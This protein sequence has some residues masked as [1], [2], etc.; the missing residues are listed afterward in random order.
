MLGL[1]VYWALATCT[2]LAGW[3][4]PGLAWSQLLTES[5]RN[6]SPRNQNPAQQLD[7]SPQSAPL[8]QAGSSRRSG[9]TLLP[10][11]GPLQAGMLKQTAAQQA[12]SAQNSDSATPVDAAQKSS[13]QGQQ[14]DLA[15]GNS[16]ANS[17]P[18]NA[19]NDEAKDDSSSQN[20]M[21]KEPPPSNKSDALKLE[22]VIASLYRYFPLIQQAR[23]ESS[24]AAGQLVGAYGAYD[25]KLQGY[26]LNEPTGFYRNYRNGIGV[27]RQ[28]WWGTYL[29]AGYR[30]GRGDFQPWYKERETNNGGEFKLAMEVPLLQGRAIDAQRVAVFQA[31]VAQQAV[32]P[33]VQQSILSTSIA[34]ASAYWEWLGAGAS[35]KAQREL[36]VLAE[37]RGEQFEIGVKAE[38]FAEIDLIFNQQLI[39]ERRAKAFEA[40]QKFRA[41][42]FKLSLFLRDDGGQ[43]IVPNDDWL[44]EYFPD[45]GPMPSNN[46]QSDLADALSRRPEPQLLRLEMQQIQYER[47]LATNNLLPRLDVI[48]EASQD[49]GVPASK[50]ND[51]GRFELLVGVQS[52]VP[53]QR[54]YA[55]GKMQ[56]TAAKIAQINEK[57]R[58]Q[59]DKIGVELQSAYNS[60]TI[61]IQVIQATELLLRTSTDTLSRYRFG[62]D[63]GKVDL[64]YINLL[65]S[66]VNEAEIKLVEAQRN[67][68]VA[69]AEMQAALGL[70]PLDQAMIISTLPLSSRPGPG[71]LPKPTEL[72]QD[73]FDKDWKIHTDPKRSGQ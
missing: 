14:S 71:R 8:Q 11:S 7:P 34:A 2:F 44:P 21:Q 52:D 17:S 33:L 64:V 31:N 63:R 46:F 68:L 45:L 12:A 59:Q 73:Q 41:T 72:E 19:A 69:L 56:E 23:L 6:N 28:T 1:K 54:R 5:Q 4:M 35:L 24:R 16:Q 3:A 70:D 18:D 25:T 55:K 32:E 50:S 53:I 57:L 58:L 40:E 27:A 49:T 13:S 29:S 67:A 47:Q 62:F 60:L 10:P 37:Q 9:T 61:A 22:D 42:A 30:I 66:K 43:P 38:K 36:L 48:S 65:E 51:K 26:T 20:T 15:T 39:A